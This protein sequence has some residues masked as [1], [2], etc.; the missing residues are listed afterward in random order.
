MRSHLSL[1]RTSR[2]ILFLISFVLAATGVGG[3]NAAADSEEW[4][5]IDPSDLAQKTPIVDPDADAEVI[6][7][8]IRVDDAGGNDLVLSHYVRIKIFNERGRERE[9]GSISRFSVAPGSKMSPRA[10]SSRM[11]RLLSWR[12][13][14]S[15]RN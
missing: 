13:R 11:V 10:S 14:M 5:P 15:S 1:H 9:S 3:R 12:K 7:W 2:L 4:R 6:F 8:D